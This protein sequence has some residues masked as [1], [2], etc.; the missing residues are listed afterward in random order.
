MGIVE[1]SEFAV[2]RG[3]ENIGGDD[4]DIF[5][6]FQKA[7]H[8]SLMRSIASN[9]GRSGSSDGFIGYMVVLE[10]YHCSIRLKLIF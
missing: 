8:A 3:A 4:S 9:F 1:V 7:S 5:V 10:Q 6:E 2:G